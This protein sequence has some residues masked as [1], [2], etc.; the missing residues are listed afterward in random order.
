MKLG[1]STLSETTQ[2]QGIHV[3]I[4]LSYVDLIFIFLRIVPLSWTI[5]RGHKP[6][7]ETDIEREEALVREDTVGYRGYKISRCDIGF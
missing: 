4:S 5:Y 3:Q 1:N 6:K 7:G 2:A